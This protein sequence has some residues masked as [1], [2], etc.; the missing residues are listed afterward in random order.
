[1]ALGRSCPQLPAMF[2]ILPLAAFA[3]FTGNSW[4]GLTP[5]INFLVPV[6]SPAVV[7]CS[8]TAAGLAFRPRLDDM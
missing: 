7:I 1:M 8:I 3:Q 5:G 4:F 6:D 2:M